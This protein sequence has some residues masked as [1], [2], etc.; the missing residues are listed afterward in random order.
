MRQSTT[1][2]VCLVSP[3]KRASP[4]GAINWRLQSTFAR[5]EHDLSLPEPVKRTIL[6]PDTQELAN[7]G[8]E[9]SL[10]D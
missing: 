5:S 4:S 1:E 10:A 9:L 6:A 3:N 7:V 2:K 8:S